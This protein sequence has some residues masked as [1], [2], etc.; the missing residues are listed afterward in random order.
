MLD[1]VTIKIVEATIGRAVTGNAQGTA[2]GFITIFFWRYRVHSVFGIS[3]EQIRA[4]ARAA[5]DADCGRV[6]VAGIDVDGAFAATAHDDEIGIERRLAHGAELLGAVDPDRGIFA[7]RAI[8]SLEGKCLH[9]LR[10]SGISGRFRAG[11]DRR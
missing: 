6:A 5:L 9:G 7:R 2:I 4:S 8:A 10:D 3:D 1:A 11:G